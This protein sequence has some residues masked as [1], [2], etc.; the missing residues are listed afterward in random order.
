MDDSAFDE[1]MMF[2]EYHHH[3]HQ[4]KP[5]SPVAHL[6]QQQQQQQ[7][8]QPLLTAFQQ[9]GDMMGYALAGTDHMDMH[10]HH[11]HQLQD[12]DMHRHHQ[13]HHGVAANAG[14]IQDQMH[15]QQDRQMQMGG[16]GG[17][18]PQDLFQIPVT[19]T[20]GGQ[21]QSTDI[22]TNGNVQKHTGIVKL[23]MDAGASLQSPTGVTTAAAVS[24][25]VGQQLQLQ[26]SGECIFVSYFSHISDGCRDN[27]YL[28]KL[29]VT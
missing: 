17:G 15:Q 4:Q 16:N 8:H 29:Y 2:N 14:I 10:H 12:M 1:S 25:V 3:H 9:S 26:S 21:V 11:H 23:E 5:G 20:A 18:D 6:H 22:A 24:A 19:S 7:H 28:I 13:H 27:V